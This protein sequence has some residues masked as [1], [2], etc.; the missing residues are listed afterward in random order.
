[1]GHQGFDM[2]NIFSFMQMK[3]RGLRDV[4][5]QRFFVLVLLFD[6]Y[7][8]NFIKNQR[9]YILGNLKFSQDSNKVIRIIIF[10]SG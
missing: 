4:L 8:L 10:D 1:M 5:L 3:S 2:C 9:M 7:L 6:Q